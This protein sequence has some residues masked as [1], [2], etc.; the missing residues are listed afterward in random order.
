MVSVIYKRRLFPLLTQSSSPPPLNSPQHTPSGGKL[1]K[2]L[3]NFQKTV[4]CVTLSPLAG[5][6]VAAAPRLLAGSLDGHVKIFEL[7]EFKVTHA[8]KY[9]S[10]V[11]SLGISGDAGLLAVGLADGTLTV[12][13]HAR[14]KV[15]EG[16]AAA[17]I[18]GG[19]S[20]AARRAARRRARLEVNASNFRWGGGF[21]SLWGRLLLSL[22]WHRHHRPPIMSSGADSC[23]WVGTF[24]TACAPSWDDHHS[25][26]MP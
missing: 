5:P 22:L 19:G 15:V 6:D 26:S 20:G 16:A 11:L 9:P 25:Y 2:R 24:E 3:A 7:D 14:P 23:F 17:A 10:P 13:K 1:I 21:Y 18:G 4:T 8:T 12:R